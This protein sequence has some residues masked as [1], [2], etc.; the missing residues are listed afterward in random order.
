MPQQLVAK[1]TIV[2]LIAVLFLGF[3]SAVDIANAGS[4]RRLLTHFNDA[5]ALRLMESSEFDTHTTRTIRE[6]QTYILAEEEDEIDEAAAALAAAHEDLD[7]LNVI[8]AADDELDRFA[9]AHLALNDRRAALLVTLSVTL[10]RVRANDIAD[11]VVFD[12]I[13]RIEREVEALSVDSRTLLNEE[14]AVIAAIAAQRVRQN[15]LVV[16][17]GIGLSLVFVL[18]GLVALQHTVV[19]PIRQL[20]D[21]NLAFAEGRLTAPVP[22]ASNDEIGV[23]QRSFNNLF[24]TICR[25]TRDLTAQATVA[26]TIRA[27]ARAAET[28]AQELAARNAQVEA[29]TVTLQAEIVERQLA[30]QALI[31]ARDAAQEADRAKSAFLATMSHELRTPLTAI[32]GFSQLASQMARDGDYSRLAEDLR[33]VQ[34]AGKHLLALINDV[35]DLSRIEAGKLALTCSTFAVAG[36][37]GE[38]EQLVKPLAERSNNSFTV[39]CPPDLGSMFSDETRV[40]QALLNLLSNAMKFTEGGHVRLSVERFENHDHPMLAFAI[41]DTG[42]GIA[43]EQQARLFQPFSQIDDSTT[44]KYGGTGLGLALSKRIAHA[45]GGMITVVSQHG[46]GSTF[47]LVLPVHWEEP[48]PDD[49]PQPSLLAAGVRAELD[50]PSQEVR[51]DSS[52]VHDVI[53]LCIDDDTAFASLLSRVLQSE[54]IAVIHAESGSLGLELAHDLLP[55]VILLDLLMPD[56]GGWEILAQL[57]ATPELAAIPVILLSIEEQFE[58]LPAETIVEYLVKPVDPAQLIDAI[59]RSGISP[60]H[61]KEFS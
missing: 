3:S 7:A 11:Q 33:Y 43:A 51:E 39:N 22:I 54:K 23:L 18:F 10:E 24:T 27:Q 42:I 29:Q 9:D 56:L 60:S 8:Q 12:E 4:M 44:R 1:V 13:E 52:A 19:R 45:L 47:T 37:V 61:H 36:L 38:I 57:K 26:D 15:Y 21:A 6:L 2:A 48:E 28:F 31:A 59:R 50:A 49:A 5:V 30:E 41:A 53:A 58:P 16:I 32:L 25:Q 14:R 34:A 40:R 35:L 17:S 55:D 46:V 20:A